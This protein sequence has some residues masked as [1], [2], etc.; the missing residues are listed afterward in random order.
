MIFFHLVQN[1]KAEMQIKHNFSHLGLL[2]LSNIVL[3]LVHLRGEE[4][5][6]AW[7]EVLQ[8]DDL[9]QFFETERLQISLFHVF[10]RIVGSCE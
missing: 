5:Q 6:V 3:A 2:L 9:T 8:L 7:V 10:N 4:D 1:G